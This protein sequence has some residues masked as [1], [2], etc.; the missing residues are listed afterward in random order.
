MCRECC[1]LILRQAFSFDL[2]R[3]SG[4]ND[5]A[6]QTFRRW[7]P[8]LIRQ[9]PM[10]PCG[11]GVAIAVGIACE[12]R[13]CKRSECPQSIADNPSLVRSFSWELTVVVAVFW[14]W[15]RCRSSGHFRS[16]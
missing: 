4:L 7:E 12:H 11:T 6:D 10:E 8:G 14:L 2:A 15:L 5:H 16:G 13:Q 9:S 3:W 1:S